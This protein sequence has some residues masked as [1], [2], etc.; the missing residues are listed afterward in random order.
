MRTDSVNL[1]N[2]AING[3]KAAIID[4]FGEVQGADSPTARRAKEAHEAIRPTDIRVQDAGADRQQQRL[5]D[6]IRKRAL[7]S[8]MADAELERTTLRID[9]PQGQ[10]EFIAKGEVVQFE[11]FLKVYFESTD[12]EDSEEQKGMLPAMQKNEK[13]QNQSITAT[14]RFTK[15]PPRYTEA[16]LKKVRGT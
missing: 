13:L 2:E 10:L 14:E 5:Y 6:L 8:Q 9:T 3:A 7:A 15:H 12:D 4:S 16:S 1:S 11:G